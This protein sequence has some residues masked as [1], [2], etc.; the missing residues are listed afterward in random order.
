MRE[1]SEG[2]EKEGWRCD[3]GR[4]GRWSVREKEGELEWEG[5]GEGNGV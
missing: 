5:E 3:G 2:G 1:E 4:R